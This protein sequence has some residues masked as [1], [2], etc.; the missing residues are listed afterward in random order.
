MPKTAVTAGIQ[1]P[2]DRKEVRHLGPRRSLSLSKGL[3]QPKRT[4]T[5]K[6]REGP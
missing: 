4:P 2:C 6:P 3:I 5:T 1:D